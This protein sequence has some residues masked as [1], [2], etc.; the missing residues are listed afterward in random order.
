MSVIPLSTIKA[1]LRVIHD[2]D[3]ETLQT[4]LDG[5]EDE[6][7]RFMNRERL[8]TLPLEYPPVYDSSS[9]E[10]S[11]ETP[12]SEDPVAPAVVEG[13]ILLVKANYE[14][15]TPADMSGYRRAAEIKLMPYRARLGV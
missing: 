9:S 8:P 11:E 15:M 7:L 1:R 4:A 12:S 2:A 13:V 10:V 14:A 3:D 6:A 5:A